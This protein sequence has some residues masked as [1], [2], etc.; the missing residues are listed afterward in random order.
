M[1]ADG[2]ERYLSLDVLQVSEESGEGQQA[3]VLEIWRSGAL[4]QTSNAILAGK[5][6]NLALEDQSVSAVVDSC[7]QDPYGYLVTISVDS[8]THWFPDAYKPAY[9]LPG[10]SARSRSAGK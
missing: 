5:K 10:N 3:I 6:I 9:L 2:D 8:G 7:E 4:L 1:P